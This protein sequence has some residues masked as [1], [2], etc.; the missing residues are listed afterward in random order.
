[1]FRTF[2]Q[3]AFLAL[4]PLPLPSPSST[5]TVSPLSLSS[6]R[7]GGAAALS[8]HGWATSS[9]CS[10]SIC[11]LARAV[12]AFAWISWVTLTLLLALLLTGGILAHR[13][14]GP[15][16]WTAPFALEG[17]V[18]TKRTPT[19]AN[20]APATPATTTTAGTANTAPV[21]MAQV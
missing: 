4:S 19:T 15:G 9:F 5:L 20:G 8:D 14:D 21:A 10:Y 17:G 18:G 2:C 13:R 7:T 16:A 6:R 12:Q 1:M 11:D 3:I